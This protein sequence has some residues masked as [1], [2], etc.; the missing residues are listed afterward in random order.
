MSGSIRSMRSSRITFA[1]AQAVELLLEEDYICQ[2]DA[3]IILRGLREA[4]EPIC[5][6][7][8]ADTHALVA[9][10]EA[11]RLMSIMMSRFN[12][13]SGSR[14]YELGDELRAR[15]LRSLDDARLPAMGAP[16]L[17]STD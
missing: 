12:S 2:A 14:Y 13:E 17:C 10:S 5:A 4:A 3:I 11:L 8:Q 9:R 7:E 16:H 1:R 6:A 15:L